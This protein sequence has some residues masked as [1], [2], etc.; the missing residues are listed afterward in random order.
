MADAKTREPEWLELKMAWA[1]MAT[2][3]PCSACGD[4]SKGNP[5]ELGTGSEERSRAVFGVSGGHRAIITI[6]GAIGKS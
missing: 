2:D 5:G 1:K 4:G 6:P 3:A